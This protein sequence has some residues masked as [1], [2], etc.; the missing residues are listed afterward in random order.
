VWYGIGGALVAW[1]VTALV[2][3]AL[4]DPVRRIAGLYGSGF[5]LSGLPLEATGALVGSA[6]LLGWLGSYIAASRHLRQIEPT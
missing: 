6:V 4:R 2:V 3:G 1:M 5:E